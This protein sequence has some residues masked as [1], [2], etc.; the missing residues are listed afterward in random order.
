[1]SLATMTVVGLIAAA[2]LVWFLFRTLAKDRL[3]AI[4]EKRRASSVLVTRGEYV[5]GLDT[6]PVALALTRDAFFYENADLEASFELDR[7]DEIEYDT[8]LATGR[9]VPAG[10]KALRLRSHGTTF[11]FLLPATDA[12]KWTAALPPRRLGRPTAQAS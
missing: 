4:L 9:P 3:A 12:E 6:M 5:E 7:V 2:V 1:M 11:E 8:E 10:V